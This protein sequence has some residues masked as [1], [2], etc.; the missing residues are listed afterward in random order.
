MKDLMHRLVMNR[1]RPYYIYQCDL[2]HGAGHFRTPISVGLEIVEA[3]RGHTSGYAVP[4]YV[5]DA[6]GGG[7]KIPVMPN[8]VISQSVDRVVVRN[9]EG[10]MSAYTQPEIYTRHDASTCSACR[11]RRS[12]SGQEGVS[13][14][15]AGE[16][17]AIQPEGFERT[18]QRL[19]RVRW[20]KIAASGA[21][22][23]TANPL[24]QAPI[25]YTK[26]NGS[27]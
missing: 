23:A 21:L 9:Y 12:E 5:I 26:E 7:G 14:L 20:G 13:A 3:L 1:V 19:T 2:V 10:Y 24:G 22:G 15:L 16:R 18:H 17:L 25:D 11:Q 4:T 6:P 27:R 8:Y